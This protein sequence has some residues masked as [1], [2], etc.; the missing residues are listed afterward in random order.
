MS[1]GADP[2]RIRY[3]GQSLGYLDG[4]EDRVLEVLSQAED[5]SP[6]SDELAAHIVDWPTRYHF[7]RHRANLLRPFAIGAAMRVLEIGAG[8]GSLS[9]FLGETGAEVVSLE[10]S[11]ARAH[12]TAAGCR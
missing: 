7:S 4:A 3:L 8:T 9:R 12:A 2:R 6:V 10:G 1:A 5:R 11:P